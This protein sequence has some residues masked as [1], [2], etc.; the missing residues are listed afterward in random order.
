MSIPAPLIPTAFAAERDRPTRLDPIRV[1]A[2]VAIPVSFWG[3]VILLIAKGYL[4]MSAAGWIA[5][6]LALVFGAGLYF[7]LKGLLRALPF[8]DRGDD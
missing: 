4:P 8:M 6:V 2:F 5:L 7:L 1:L 3:T